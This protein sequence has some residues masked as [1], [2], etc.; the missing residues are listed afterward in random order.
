LISKLERDC[1]ILAN[2]QRFIVEVVEEVLIL[3]NKKKV[4]LVE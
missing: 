2:K 1:Q 4:K 3:R